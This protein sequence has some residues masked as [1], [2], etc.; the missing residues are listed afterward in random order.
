MQDLKSFIREV[1]DFPSPG[2]N[3][4]DI[5]T[6][7]KDPLG[8]QMTVDRLCWL[9]H[10]DQVDKVIGMESRGFIFAPIVASRLNAGFVPV[11]KPGKLPA[12]TF[13]QSYALEYGTD[14][15]E[16]HADAIEAGERVLIID[17]LI[18]TGGTARA[19]AELVT[20]A[21]GEVVGFGFVIE[22]E[23]LDGRSLLTD[24]SVKSLIVY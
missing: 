3:F 23:A 10:S 19:T 21:G 8:L 17:D 20:A 4:Y 5:T 15:L 9:F 12:E 1:P 2:I 22:L 6:L 11:R 14:T 18:A 16:M 7:M 13:E 24:Y